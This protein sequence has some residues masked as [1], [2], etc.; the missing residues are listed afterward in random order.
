MNVHRSRITLL[1]TVLGVQM[2]WATTASGQR[3]PAQLDQY[4]RWING[5]SEPWMFSESTSKEE[6]NSAQ[7]RWSE[8]GAENGAGVE[9]PWVGT[10]FAGSET[11][12]SYLRWSLRNGFVLMQVDKCAAQVM[13]FSY[14]S[15]I[16]NQDRI[17]LLPLKTVS[18]TTGHGHVMAPSLRFL[19]VTWRG[20]RYL[21]P[22]DEIAD[23]GNYIA[24]LGKYNDWAGNY[25]EVV[26][27][28]AK[29]EREVAGTVDELARPT[30]S[31]KEEREIDLP[32]VPPGFER[33][34]KRPIDITITGVGKAW[35]RRDGENPW[36]DHLIVP[37][38]VSAGQ[39]EGVSTKMKFRMAD[40]DE[41]IIVTKAGAHSS[42]AIVVRSTR[43]KPCVKF[44]KDDDCGDMDYSSIRVGFKASTSAF[45]WNN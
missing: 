8:I 22:E 36:W 23:F 16:F 26:E 39:A 11:H 43:K 18:S 3:S 5:I 40:S 38:T 20:D 13:G 27:F 32:I 45:R 17:Q 41:I 25:I 31:N 2:L 10:Y 4:G 6:I 24:G 19:P 37:I 33:F 7:Q 29:L 34:I 15:V 35:V 28:F 14:G 9:K 1:V 21:V 42:Q 44:S 30:A 12:G